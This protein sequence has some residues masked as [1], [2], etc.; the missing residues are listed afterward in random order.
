VWGWAVG[1]TDECVAKFF[2]RLHPIPHPP[3]KSVQA[4]K[5]GL[6]PTSQPTEQ[7]MNNFKF[8]VLAV[9]T[10][11][12]FAAQTP[13]HAQSLTQPASVDRNNINAR[14]TVNGA[15]TPDRRR[16]RQLRQRH[17]RLPGSTRRPESPRR[18]RGRQP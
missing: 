5:T 14:G 4:A 6:Q 18:R 16:R 12:A 2:R 11:A 3:R 15:I 8:A 7:T 10:L 9:A 1:A 13:V 17:A